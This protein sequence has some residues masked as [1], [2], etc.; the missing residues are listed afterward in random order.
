MNF[1]GIGFFAVLQFAEAALDRKWSVQMPQ[2][3]SV[4]IGSC[5]IIPCNFHHP[6]VGKNWM[7]L[8]GGSNPNDPGV[9]IIYNAKD[10]LSVDVAYQTRSGMMS[11]ENPNDCSLWISAIRNEDQGE[12]YITATVD[13]KRSPTDPVFLSVVEKPN[14]SVSEEITAGNLVT[15]TCSLIQSCPD[16]KIDLKWIN[17]TD[18]GAALSDSKSKDIDTGFDHPDWKGSQE[19]SAVLTFTALRH[20]DGKMLGCEI[21]LNEHSHGI[22]QMV[23]LDI[24][25]PPTEPVPTSPSVILLGR[26]AF[27]RCSTNSNPE[28]W[29]ELVKDG[30]ILSN[31]SLNNVLTAEFSSITFEDE[32]QYFCYAANKHGTSV[33][34]INITVEYSPSKPQINS[35]LTVREGSS[36][37]IYCITQSKPESRLQWMKDGAPI[38]NSYSGNVVT[39]M[40]ADIKYADDGYYQCEAR[41][42]HGTV[43]SWMNITVEYAPWKPMV[44][45]SIVALEGQS[46]FIYCKGQGNP[47]VSLSWV[48]NGEEINKSFSSELKV[49]FNNISLNE[50][51]NF[52]CMAE[53]SLGTANSSIQI[54]VEY[55]PR[56]VEPANCSRSQNNINCVCIVKGNPPVQHVI[57]SLNGKNITGNSPDV[58]VASSVMDGNLILSKLTLSKELGLDHNVSCYG[59][60]KHGVTFSSLQLD[61]PGRPDYK[62]IVGIGAAGLITIVLVVIC[63]AMKFRKR[64]RCNDVLRY[65]RTEKAE[66]VENEPDNEGREVISNSTEQNEEIHY[67]SVN[68][69]AIHSG[70]GYVRC[71]DMSEYANLKFSSKGPEHTETAFSES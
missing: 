14:I 35:S 39:K 46:L 3:L 20:H 70:D 13:G 5:V 8:K 56:M 24:Q 17:G 21:L 22:R 6:L 53:N 55:P 62:L 9:T 37:L 29:L 43:S 36:L 10:I 52:W 41:N 69:A 57:W 51:G 66:H 28:S 12:Y 32:G 15:V 44:N 25:Y 59:A 60:N 67:A 11:S 47:P 2:R 48:R 50:D 49:V 54:S 33:S 71:K 58:G 23:T 68:F 65:S 64:K 27:I 34:S 40:F 45:S 16:A 26:S 31:S 18:F 1:L 7:W 63:V 42:K 4:L 38:S 30:I 19:V 61:L